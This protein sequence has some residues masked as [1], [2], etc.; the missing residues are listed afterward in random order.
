MGAEVVAMC[1]RADRQWGM[2]V[3]PSASAHRPRGTGLSFHARVMD[4]RC[5]VAAARASDHWLL[6]RL[7]VRARLGYGEPT[8]RVRGATLCAGAPVFKHRF[9][10][11]SSN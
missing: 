2:A 11:P 4:L 9:I 8:W 3:R 5:T 10:Y 6:W 1:D 7:S